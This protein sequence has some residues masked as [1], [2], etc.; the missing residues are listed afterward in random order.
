M[1]WEERGGRRYYY[2]KVRKG[3]RVFSVYVGGGIAG[4]LASQLDEADR[5][6]RDRDRED[7]RRELARQDEADALVE[8][9]WRVAQ[10]AERAILEEAGYHLHNRQWRLR[11]NGE[12]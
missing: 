6:E 7:L 2:R 8:R 5:K 11:R 12:A 10:D 4:T 9:S 1:P 3:G